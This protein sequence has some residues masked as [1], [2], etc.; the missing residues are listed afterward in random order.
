MS[1]VGNNWK[2]KEKKLYMSFFEELHKVETRHKEM[3][4]VIKIKLFEQ[5]FSIHADQEI[6]NIIDKIVY[7]FEYKENERIV[8]EI[9]KKEGKK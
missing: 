1:R 9:N 3:I 2:L 7:E 4:K 6:G 8:N 5:G